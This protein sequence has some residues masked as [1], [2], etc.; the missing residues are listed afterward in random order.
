MLLNK[1]AQKEGLKVYPEIAGDLFTEDIKDIKFQNHRRILQNHPEA[2]S[3][4]KDIMNLIYFYKILESF[5][6]TVYFVIS[7]A[8]LFIHVIK[9]IY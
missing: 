3:L 2:I 4:I 8:L 6:L 9:V 5:K 1:L 7:L